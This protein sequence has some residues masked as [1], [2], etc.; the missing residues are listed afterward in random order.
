MLAGE[1]IDNSCTEEELTASDLVYFKY[2]P[3]VSADV[4]RSF[5]WYK[6][7]VFRQ[8]ALPNF[9]YSAQVGVC[10]LQEIR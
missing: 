1:S 3:V 5:S 9:Q 8:Q 4:E 10:L 6:K 2:A 7:C